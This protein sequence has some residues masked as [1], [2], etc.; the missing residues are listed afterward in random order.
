MRH[1]GWLNTLCRAALIIATQRPS[2]DVITGVKANIPSRIAFPWYQIDYDNFRYG[3]AEKLLGRGD[4]LF[5]PSVLINQQN[6]GGFV[7]K[8]SREGVT[9]LRTIRAP[10]Y[11][12]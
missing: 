2:V 10:D 9:L 11:E 1:A 12:T 7:S 5:I 8:R 3:G 4:M 6:T